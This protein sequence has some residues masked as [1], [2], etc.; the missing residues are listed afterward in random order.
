MNE[1]RCAV[2][3][4]RTIILQALATAGQTTVKCEPSPLDVSLWHRPTVA[5]KHMADGPDR[6]I[7]GAYSLGVDALWEVVAVGPADTVDELGA[8]SEIAHRAIENTHG[9]NPDGHV[10]FCLR[11]R[12]VSF[13]F[14]GE[15]GNRYHQVG[16]IYRLRVKGEHGSG[17]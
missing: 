5:L 8:L 2:R 15:D 4:L 3:H 16:G 17:L 1:Q 11:E 14:V 7:T 13:P 10:R 6:R 9:E 12:T